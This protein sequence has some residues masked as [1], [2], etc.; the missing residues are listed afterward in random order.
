MTTEEKKTEMLRL[1]EEHAG[2]VT[3]A[4]K[5]LGIHRE[6]YRRWCKADPDFAGSAMMI[7]GSHKEARMAEAARRPRRAKA[8]ARETPEDDGLRRNSATD[9]AALR[10]EHAERLRAALKERG[11]YDAGLEPQIRS[12]ASTWAAIARCEEVT[13]VYSPMQVEISREGNP[14]ITTNGTYEQLRRLQE[15]YTRQMQALGL[16]FDAKATPKEEDAFGEFMA[17]LN[18]DDDEDR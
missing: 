13:D 3:K 9:G 10:A 4:C 5:A 11:I 17:R 8:A 18:K 7:I 1:L 6:I 14:R 2:N 15:T 12:A 16:N